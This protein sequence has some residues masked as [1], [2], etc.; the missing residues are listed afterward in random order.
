MNAALP[1][2]NRVRLDELLVLRGDFA[3]RS[4]ARDAIERGAVR[5]DGEV[6]TK[7]GRSVA[8]QTPIRIDDPARN[9]VSRAALKLIAGLDHFQLDPSGRHALDIGASSGGFTQVL[10]E[11]G[12]AHVTAID[13][14]HGQ[15]DAGLR[16]D[17]RVTAIEGLNARDL[18]SGH[19]GAEQ[20]GFLVCDVSFISLKLAL[21]PALAL[22]ASGACAMLLVKPQFEAGRAA[23][24]KGGLLRDPY[25]GVRIAAALSA[26]LD[27]VKAWRTLG[28][29]PSPI[30]GGDGN[31]EFL[32]AGIKDR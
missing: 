14:G 4:R 17:P 20:P 24:G 7:P 25:Q 22:M 13:V 6:A 2:S 9:Y 16:A 31:R 5:V 26:W 10:L 19:L 23:I 11:R 29:C 30:D 8:L 18:G 28:F 12:A 21:P 1:T 27:S 32:L 15:L 3:T